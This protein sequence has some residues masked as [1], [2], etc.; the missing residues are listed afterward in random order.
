MRIK[1]FL[2]LLFFMVAAVAGIA[3]K[4]DTVIPKEYPI[5]TLGFV[6][7]PEPRDT[8]RGN[9]EAVKVIAAKTDTGKKITKV[10]TSTATAFSPRRAAIRSA[11]IPG[12]GQVYN[13]KYWKVP[14]VYAAL[15][16]TGAT[17]RYNLKTYKDISFAYRTL[18]ARDTPNYNNV[19]TYLSEFVKRGDQ[20][21]LNN[22]RAEFR[23]NIDYSVLFFL[24][25]WGLNVVDAT[26]DAHLKGF[27]VNNDLSMKIKPAFNTGGSGPGLSLVFDI[28]Q[29]QYKLRVLPQ[30]R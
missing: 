30:D 21:A 23:K 12:W 25:F 4:K 20:N 9:R 24:F 19:A 27:N 5:D 7:K 11:I 14:L 2:F 17:F 6:K 28:H 15:G 16:I 29:P 26:V 10:D 13:K 18:V 1:P 3:Q 22:Y 8:L